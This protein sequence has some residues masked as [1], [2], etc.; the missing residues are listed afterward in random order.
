MYK[1]V[2]LIIVGF[3]RIIICI[4]K[5]ENDLNLVYIVDCI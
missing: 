5:F 4:G 1:F 3:L 2:V